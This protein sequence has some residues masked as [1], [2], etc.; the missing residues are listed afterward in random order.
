MTDGVL[1]KPGMTKSH[2]YVLQW[3]WGI[4]LNIIGACVFVYAL[5]AKWPI[6]KYRNAI[7]MEAPKSFGGLNLG[8]FLMVGKGN[9]SSVAH[10]YGHS[11]QNLT[12]GLLM[13][14]V[15]AIP[16]AIRYWHRR[17][18]YLDKGLTPPTTYDSVW[19]EGQATSLGKRAEAGEWSWV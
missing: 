2:Y 3:T 13:P 18:K 9:R 17:I 8:M 14:F 16:S 12:W 7:L 10:E 11:L 4:I 15:I 5:I 19:F 6:S 1:S